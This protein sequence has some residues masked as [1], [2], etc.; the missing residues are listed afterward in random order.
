MTKVSSMIAQLLTVPEVFVDV[1]G[2]K[3]LARVVKTFPPKKLM[4][5]EGNPY[6]P[7]ATDLGLSNEE[8]AESDDPMKYFY[9]VRLIEEGGDAEREGSSTDSRDEHKGE[10]WQSSVME[11]Q[12]DKISRDRINFS[13]AMLKRFIRDCVSR[14]AAIYSPWL[15]KK[16]VAQHYG[17][18]TEMTDEIRAAIQLNRERQMD[19]RKR[20]RE[21]RL[22]IAHSDD[23]VKEEAPPAKKKKM[24]KAERE[25][26]EKEKKEREEEEKKK[27]RG[28]KYPIEGELHRQALLTS[29]MLLEYA[30]ER[31]EPAGRIEVRPAPDKDLPFGEEFEKFFMAWS[32]LNVMGEGLGLSSFTIDEFEQALYHKD[33]YTGPVPLL[34]EIHSTLLNALVRDLKAGHDPVRP[35]AHCGQVAD[36]DTD[37]WEGTK[38]ATTET[39]RPVA[40]TAAETWSKKELSPNNDRKGWE[41][42]LVGCLWERATLDT[43]PQYLDNI[44]YLTFE[45]KPAPTRPTWSTGPSSGTTASGLILAKPE[46]RYT[47]LHFLHKLNIINFLIELVAQTSVI[48]DFMEE[49]TQAL[50][51]VRKEQIEAKREWRRV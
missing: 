51:E 22:G 11:V 29:D 26:E 6:H 27:K 1:Q 31:D 13:R 46:K 47:S 2:D 38:G 9:N 12:A 16:S 49:S 36:N 20:D 5:P 35:L 48:R 21:E 34:V 45:D 42:A 25:K 41:M 3:Y 50:T 23:E 44:L 14:D 32:F 7:Y 18:P 24:S 15:V 28:I 19:K 33:N 37:Y 39:L 30:P 8:V 17:L 40:E 4:A 10:M 43:L